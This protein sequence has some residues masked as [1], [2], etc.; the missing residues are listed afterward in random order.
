MKKDI[1][2][3]RM[4]KGLRVSMAKIKVMASGTDE[5]PM[6]TSGRYPCG[7]C[8][9]GVWCELGILYFLQPIGA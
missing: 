2:L 4:C 7:V 1:L 5:G 6:L 3:G 9:K 8:R